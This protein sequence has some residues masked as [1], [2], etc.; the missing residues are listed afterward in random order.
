V[1]RGSAATRLLTVALFIAYPAL[2]WFAFSRGSARSA[3]LWLLALAAPLTI[4]SLRQ[5]ATQVARTLGAAPFLTVGAL[6]LTALFDTAEFVLAV[7]AAVNGLFLLAFASTLRPSAMPM[8]ERFARLELDAPSP[9][10]LAW[11]RRWT[12]IWS[13]YFALNGLVCGLLA[14]LAP[15]RVWAVYCGLVAYVFS[16]ALF[17]AE[18]LGRRRR[19]G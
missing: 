5:R 13:V 9:A 11:C 8:V 16:G 19:F 14:W 1:S 4:L 6:V 2:V 3:A 15:L 18:Y 7:P 17:A 12:Q 10:Q